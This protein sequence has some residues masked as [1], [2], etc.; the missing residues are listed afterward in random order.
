MKIYKKSIVS[1]LAAG[2]FLTGLLFAVEGESGKNTDKLGS[3]QKPRIADTG[4]FDGNRI[5][6]DL[7][8]NGMIVSH[9]ISGRSGMSWPKGNNTQ[10]IFAS[11]IWVAGKVGGQIRMAAG[12]YGGEFVG[13]PWGSDPSDPYHKLYKVNKTDLDDPAAYADF[14]NWPTEFGAPWVDNNANGTYEPLPNGPDHPKFTGDQVVWAVMNDGDPTQHVIFGTAP[15]DIEMQMTIFGYDRVDA[16]GDMMF[17]KQLIINKGEHPI[18]DM[19]IGLW[20]DPDLGDAGDDFVACDTTLSL[21]ICY[22]DGVDRFFAGYVNG[23]PAVGYDFFQGPIVPAPGETALVSGLEIPDFKNLQMSSFTKYI[24]GDPVYFDPNDAI[25][26]YN[27]MMGFMPDGSDFPF[28]A[29]GGTKF[30]HPDDPN[31]DTG[32]DDDVLVDSDLHASGDRRFLMNVGPFTMQPGESQEIV[33]GIFHAA[34]GDAL[35]SFSLLKTIDRQAQFAYDAQFI[36]PS[37]PRKPEVEVTAFDDA[38]VLKWDHKA[39]DYQEKGPKDLDG[40]D[41]YFEFEGY[42]VYQYSAA[43]GAN[44]VLVATYD[45]INNIQS[46]KDDVYDIGV[47]QIINK[48]VYFGTDSGLKRSISITKDFQTNLPLKPNRV[49]YYGVTAYSYDEF[50]SPNVLESSPEIMS[51]RPHTS[52]T[53]EATDET[54]LYGTILEAEHTAGPSDGVARATVIDPM[55]LTG[56]DY[57]LF[58]TDETYY[59]DVDGI[60]KNTNAA[61]KEGL[62]KILDCGGSMVSVAALA[63]AVIGTYDLTFTFEMDC[64]SNWVDGIQLV[65]PAGVVINSWGATGE[66][67]DGGQNCVNME[68]TLD[69]ATNTI[70][71][72]NDGRTGWGC[73]EGDV[74]WVVNVQPADFP[75]NVDYTVWDDVYDGSLV[76]AVG[77]ATATE[78]GFDLKTFEGWYA[79]NLTTN[80]IVTPHTTI[81]SG[82]A[83]D[84][85]IDG[86]FFPAQVAGNNAGPIAEGLQFAVD[87]PAL[88]IKS[89]SE[90]D[91][92]DVELDPNVGLYPPSLGTTGY[93]LSHRDHA[94]LGA[95]R[96]HDRF[97][98]WGMD[99]VIIDFSETSLCFSY[100]GATPITETVSGDQSMAPYAMYRKKFPS[101]EMMRLF[102]GWWDTDGDGIWG[103]TD[104]YWTEGVYG[105][106]SYEGMYAW[107]GYDADGNEIPYDPANDA[108]YI[109]D[110]GLPNDTGHSFG[111]NP[112]FFNYPFV[113]ATMVVLYT[114]DL[115]PPWGNRIWLKTN[116][117]NTPADKFVVSTSAVVGNTVAYDPDAINVWPNPYFGYNPEERDPIEQIVQFTHLPE[118]G[119]CTIRIFNIAGIL[120][121]TIQRTEGTSIATWDL[122]NNSRIPVA[123][124]MYIAVVETDKGSKILKLAII[125]PEQRLDVY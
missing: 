8:N 50:A 18:T 44:P 72:G 95:G 102:T 113:T 21:G 81:Q 118:S 57:E 119:K 96:T 49:Y 29:T 125:Q 89:V 76:D 116:K 94:G 73:I 60:W 32:P 69:A 2:L 121:R 104:P 34:A 103:A 101:G 63:S 55:E 122:K 46:I 36:L 64:G 56:A 30:V 26:A 59:R 15:L 80:E 41:S 117:A 12:E 123:S 110:G 35:K 54:G 120:V 93:I 6:N 48:V 88:G 58:F 82:F 67:A 47:G 99:D 1:M 38:I 109:A 86:V 124:E 19:Y 83:E 52:D 70:T 115:T 22:N 77:T 97:D 14:Q 16:F 45:V 111:S 25:E 42:N 91:L 43:S 9:N 24:N 28:A 107:Q 11:G 74:E 13:G 79:R 37:A 51:V 90:T 10:T 98:F 4:S 92:D 75:I 20:S 68:G 65:F 5:D 53:W 33:F 71:W 106:Q 114:G 31:D 62:A 40:N 112:G 3:L 61:G 23:T 39:E 87:G 84:N 7:E 17:V 78:L 105:K 100:S 27:Y 108:A 66:N 85:V